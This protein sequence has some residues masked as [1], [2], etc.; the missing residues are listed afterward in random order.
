M[1][2]SNNG[3]SN[4]SMFWKSDWEQLLEHDDY[5]GARSA[6]CGMKYTGVAQSV[7][8]LKSQKN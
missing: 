8:N 1:S 2:F 6:M 3:P 7:L 4:I 5:V